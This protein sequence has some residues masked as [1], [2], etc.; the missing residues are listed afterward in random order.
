MALNPNPFDQ[1][2]NPG[3]SGA[4]QSASTANPFDQ[5][6][7]E[8]PNTTTVNKTPGNGPV[9]APETFKSA[10]STGGVDPQRFA[11]FLNGVMTPYAGAEQLLS[12]GLGYIAP[13]TGAA[14]QQGA[15]QRAA[16]LAAE[17]QEQMKYSGNAPG[18]TDWYNIAGQAASPINYVGGEGAL[19]ATKALPVIGRVAEG[20]NILKGAAQGAAMG[21]LQPVVTQP[22]Q[23][24]ATEKLGQVE[25]AALTGGVAAPVT[26]AIGAAIKPALSAAVQQLVGSDVRLTPGQLLGGYTQRA[27]SIAESYP[28]AGQLVRNAREQSLNDFQIA[29]G[30]KVLAEIGQRVDKGVKPGPDLVSNIEDKISAEYNRIHPRV[31]LTLDQPLAQDLHQIARNATGIVDQ[32]SLDQFNRILQSQ[33]FDKLTANNNLAPGKVV[34]TI[35]SEIGRLGQGFRAD[36]GIN[37][38]Y[39]GGYLADVREAIGDALARQNPADAVDLQKANNAWRLYAKLR[40]AAG[41]QGGEL[42]EFSPTQLEMAAKKGAT[43]GQK[44]KGEAPLQ[45]FAAAGKQVLPSQVANSG[46]PERTALMGALHA[47]QIGG[48][49]ALGPSALIPGLSI[50]ALYSPAGQYLLRKAI[51]DRPV[52]AQAVRDILQKYAPQIGGRAALGNQ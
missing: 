9:N 15:D 41:R 21:A 3:A 12:R 52:G 35:T 10:P 20:S 45:A 50:A 32:N 7:S 40:D 11:R 34:Q 28:F 16:Q 42:G 31:S 22:G 29:S 19:A 17:K 51:V 36:P 38:K 44:A 4:A 1:F 6:D 37:A 8:H 24:Y 26:S 18:A 14:W 30:N 5:F 2:D 27:E 33:V 46:T 23:D 13:E 25:N 49:Y 43:A 48:A 39:L 47:G